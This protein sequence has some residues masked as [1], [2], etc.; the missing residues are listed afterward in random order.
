MLEIKN[1]KKSFG[2]NVILDGIDFHVREGDVVSII[3]PSGSGKTT[4]LRCVNF[5]D[6]ADSGTIRIDG[7]SA[8]FAR[9]RSKQKI[10]IRR[11]TAMVFQN[12]ALFFNMTAVQNVMEGLLVSKKTGKDEAR[13]IA[14]SVLVKVGLGGKF[15]AKPHELSG[16]QQQ[17]VGIARAVALS[18][19]VILF[20]EPTSALDPEMVD[21]ILGLIKQVAKEGATMVIVTHEMQFAYEISNRVVFIENGKIHAEGSPRDIFDNPQGERLK[22]FVSRFSPR[23]DPEYFL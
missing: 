10:A 6:S 7:L 15:D 4:L 19:K 1:I 20:D 12:Y 14:E 2:Q 23:R 13:A 21:D 5:L 3:G 18:P 11:K 17:R 9:V 22:Q 8:D 16:G